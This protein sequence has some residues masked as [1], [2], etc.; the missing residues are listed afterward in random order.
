[1]SK[2]VTKLMVLIAMMQGALLAA[3]LNT[4]IV[5]VGGGSA[6][7]AAA[8]NAARLGT[9]VIL[10]ER[11][12]ELG[13]T[14]TVGGVSNWEPDCSG[15]GTPRILYD[16]LHAQ[17]AAGPY[18]IQRHCGWDDPKDGVFPGAMCVIDNNLCYTNT[19]RRH[20][21]GMGNKE[22]FRAN[23]H[24][25][26][27]E[28]RAMA[29]TMQK[30]LE[31][32]GHCRVML[33]TPFIAAERD[34]QG[35]VTVLKLADGNTVRAKIVIDACG[36][37]CKAIGCKVMTAE[38]PNGATLIYRLTY[39]GERCAEELAAQP[40]PDCH[41][42]VFCGK[43]PSGDIMVNMLP[44]ISGAE[45]AKMSRDELYATCRKRVFANWAWLK[46]RWP[47]FAQWRIKEVCSEVACRET[48][49][50]EGDYILT[51][52][53]VINGVHPADEIAVADHALDS[54]GVKGARSGELQQPYGIPYRSLL[55]KGTTNMLIAGRCASFDNAA[56]S[57]CRLQRTMMQLGEAAGIAAHVALINA[58]PLCS[59]TR[60]QIDA[61]RPVTIN[62]AP[63]RRFVLADESRAKVHFW[64]S[65]D[66]AACFSVPVEKPV[67]DLK[68]MGEG[69]YRI[70]CKKG[71]MLVD[72]FARKVTETFRHPSLDEVTAICDLPDGGFIASVNPPQGDPLY[73]KAVLIRRFSA[74]RKLVATYQLDGLFY[75]RSMNPD[76][77]Q[78]CFLLAW[79]H[80][81]VRFRIDP[82]ASNNICKTI[83]SYPQPVGRNLFDVEV[84]RSGEGY[85]AGI[86]YGGELIHFATD[87]R[88]LSRW[89]NP[90]RSHF[91]AQMQEM[92]DG[93]VYM[94]QWTGHGERDSEKGA[95]VIHFSP[96][97]QIL[98]TLDD[99]SRFGSISGIHVIGW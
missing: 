54:H 99:P 72:L 62:S 90:S 46:Q 37:V 38:K 58:I 6:G 61:L 9:S 81:F 50:I 85:W 18:I 76:R 34:A 3:E 1:M 89:R 49:R 59:V 44:T 13:G 92:P 47:N 53:D 73:R 63:H 12:K 96:S 42:Y 39:G 48:F 27:F 21:P 55:P 36:A 26:I 88:M 45:A 11:A 71:F 97:G 25:V 57:S 7:F 35:N 43:L 2:Y 86:G 64:D 51:A 52:D 28:P 93:S 30:M 98:W 5:V 68:R 60:N 16:R 79:E 41:Q 66:S 19:L 95:Q 80:G 74:A 84:D 69:L 15:V 4:D 67:W 8:W 94:A 24:G 33:N 10:I 14:S 77:E 20:G 87:G 75:A 29:A 23:C 32:T 78:W 65:Q 17:G 22:W 70:V 31:E 82:V 83:Q 56:A 91:F 40:L